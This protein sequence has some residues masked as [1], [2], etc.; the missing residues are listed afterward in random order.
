MEFLNSVQ[1]Y[2]GNLLILNKY[3]P[4]PVFVELNHWDGGTALLFS[5]AS[6]LRQ[7]KICLD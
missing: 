2:S 4:V 7:D 5:P 6:K 1:G 3:H